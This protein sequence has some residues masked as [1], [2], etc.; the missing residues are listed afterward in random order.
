MTTEKDVRA[1]L[2]SVIDPEIGANLI[3]LNMVKQITISED[4]EAHQRK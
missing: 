4:K 2:A 3:E 1:A